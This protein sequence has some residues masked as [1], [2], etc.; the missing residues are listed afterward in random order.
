MNRLQ[1]LL[2]LLGVVVLFLMG[3]LAY[4]LPRWWFFSGSAFSTWRSCCTS[5][6]TSPMRSFKFSLPMLLQKLES[7][8]PSLNQ[9][10]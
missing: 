1:Q 3:Y 4:G 9:A 2:W 8:K 7:K 6:A 5:K 10:C